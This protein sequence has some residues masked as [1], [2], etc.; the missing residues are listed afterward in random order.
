MNFRMGLCTICVVEV[1]PI[2]FATSQHSYKKQSNNTVAR[3][4]KAMLSF[5]AE[6]L[7]AF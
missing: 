5:N 4:Q 6:I 1:G 3:L 2:K 7:Y